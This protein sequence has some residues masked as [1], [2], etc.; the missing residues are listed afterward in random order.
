MRPYLFAGL[1]LLLTGCSP[2]GM[3]ISTTN[4]QT[5]LEE[6][7]YRIVA[8]NVRGVADATYILSLTSTYGPVAQTLALA[9]IAG[10]TSLYS[11]AM[12]DLWRNVATHVGTIEGRSLGLIHIR[13]DVDVLNLILINK[14]KLTVSADV[15]EF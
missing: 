13:Y 1:L 15:V 5:K 10:S 7:N 9:R 2:G 6:G 12:A 8:H 3:L 4:T 14:V 11:D